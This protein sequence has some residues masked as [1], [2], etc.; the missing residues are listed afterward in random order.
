MCVW[1]GGG[2]KEREKGGRREGEERG[3]GGR[4][5]G[6]RGKG[7]SGL[8]TPALV[9]PY[10]LAYLND[11]CLGKACLSTDLGWCGGKLWGGGKSGEGLHCF[12]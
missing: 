11:G 1:E 4:E 9:S 3:E 6:G 12:H 5:G 8:L 7:M 10:P 2:G